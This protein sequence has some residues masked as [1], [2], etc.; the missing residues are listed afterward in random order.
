MAKRI[1][2]DFEE[3]KEFIKD[4]PCGKGKIAEDIIK[5]LSFMTETM[6]GLQKQIEK[7]GAVVKAIN[8]NGFEVMSEH[9]AHKAYTTL[10]GR[11]NP[12]CKTLAE[13]LGEAA[14]GAEKES[15]ALMNFLRRDGK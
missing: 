1:K 7:E 12:L 11:Y 6:D 2:S 3:L 9:P 4:L 8:G 15:D 14:C 13:I 10:I 5:R